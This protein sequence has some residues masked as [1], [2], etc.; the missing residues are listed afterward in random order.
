MGGWSEGSQRVVS[1]GEMNIF[2]L[3][4]WKKINENR[5]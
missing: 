1:R 5:N 4:Q 2:S 3:T